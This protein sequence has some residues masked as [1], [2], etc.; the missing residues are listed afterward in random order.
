[1][2]FYGIVFT[3]GAVGGYSLTR[4]I[5][6]RRERT[7]ATP[8]FVAK[9]KEIVESKEIIVEEPKDFEELVKLLKDKF[10]VSDVTLSTTDGFPIASTIEDPEEISALA[11]E[12]LKSVGRVLKSRDFI[13]SSKDRKIAVFEINPEIICTI[14]ADRDIH[15]VEIEKIRE[16]I[17]K[18]MEV[19][20]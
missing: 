20:A 7:F 1:M 3:I 13:I 17:L 12:L 4:L 8:K 9:K 14:Q 10:M 6:K 11:P 15:F 19:R 5:L 16:E 18:F 2:I